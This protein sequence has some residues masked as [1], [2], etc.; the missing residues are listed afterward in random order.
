[1]ML[2][3]GKESAYFDPRCSNSHSFLGVC[4]QSRSLFW[5]SVIMLYFT[6]YSTLKICILRTNY[7]FTGEASEQHMLGE[8][9]WRFLGRT[10][11]RHRPPQGKLTDY[12]EMRSLHETQIL[13]LLPLSNVLRVKDTLPVLFLRLQ[14]K[15]NLTAF[16]KTKFCYAIWG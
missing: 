9:W 8:L 13:S 15:R 14:T 2:L 7:I 10:E 3:I 11:V 4:F 5:T 16:P 12:Y 1:M 6:L